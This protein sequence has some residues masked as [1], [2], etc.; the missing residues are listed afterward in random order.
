VLHTRPGEPLTPATPSFVT[1]R[2]KATL[3]SAKPTGALL[4]GT[5]ESSSRR[6]VR[7]SSFGTRIDDA[8][9]HKVS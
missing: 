1:T 4:G 3:G 2:C 9:G 6:A 8:S 7:G 5:M